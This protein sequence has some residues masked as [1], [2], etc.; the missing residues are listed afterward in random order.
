MALGL[1][2]RIAALSTHGQAMVEEQGL[3]SLLRRR[4]ALHQLIDP[5][6]LG[7]FGFLVQSKGL[8][9]AETAQPLKGLSLPSA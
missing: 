5:L 8:T 3:A 1:G 2:D 4:Q 6:G 7:G 9:K